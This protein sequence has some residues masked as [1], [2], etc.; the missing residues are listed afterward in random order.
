MVTNLS[1]DVKGPD[2]G[3]YRKIIRRYTSCQ[4][5]SCP[6]IDMEYVNH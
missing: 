2:G 5:C 1:T 3:I 4:Q 6:R